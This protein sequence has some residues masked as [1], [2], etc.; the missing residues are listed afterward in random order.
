MYFVQ[1]SILKSEGHGPDVA[2]EYRDKF[3]LFGKLS[4]K[5]TDKI[6][7]LLY[8]SENYTSASDFK[9]FVNGIVGSWSS[10][11]KQ[12]KVFCIYFTFMHFSYKYLQD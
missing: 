2:L 8:L 3:E 6:Q 7:S 1:V 9:Q 11:N 5:L 4:C 12:V 10:I